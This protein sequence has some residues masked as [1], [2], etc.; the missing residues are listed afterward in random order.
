MLI[1]TCRTA[2]PSKSA[3]RVAAIEVALN[4]FLDNR[5][6]EPMLFLE[7]ALILR[8]EL[9]EVME[10]HPVEDG[11]LGMSRTIGSRHGGRRAPRKGPDRTKS[12]LWT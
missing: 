1:R 10:Q 8:E 5:P 11:T 12:T 4:D 6:E 7:A 3:A 2:D 9:I